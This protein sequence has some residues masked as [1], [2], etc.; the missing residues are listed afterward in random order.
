MVNFHFVERWAK[1]VVGR[2]SFQNMR[3]LI[4]VTMLG[5]ISQIKIEIGKEKTTI[6]PISII[7]KYNI[8]KSVLVFFYK[9]KCNRTYVQCETAPFIN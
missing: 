4:N 6:R 8:K 2:N 1:R 3:R 7:I 5:Q 9:Q